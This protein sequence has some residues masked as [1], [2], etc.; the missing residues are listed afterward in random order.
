[1]DVGFIGL[2]SMGRGMARNLIKAGH[3]VSVFNRSKEPADELAREGALKAGS[4]AAVGGE[5]VVTMLSDD[6]ALEAVVL[7]S[8]GLIT[9]MRRGAVHLSMSTVSVA[10]S[11]RLEDAHRNANQA[12]V[13]APVFGRP[14]AAAAGKLFIVAAGGHQAIER[15]RPVMNAM[16]QRIFEVGGKASQANIVKLAGNFLITC[17]IEGFAETM[18]LNSKAGVAPEK[19]YEVMTESLFN[20]PVYRNYGRII[21]DGAY[22]PP[23][24]KLPLGLK[25][26]RL[27]LQAADSL[28]VPLPFA[29]V[30]RDRFLASL[31]KGD[32]DLDW[33]AIAKRAR[34][35]AGLEPTIA[36]S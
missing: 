33:A 34:E 6:A 18:A 14:D 23:G 29:A 32:G 1:M 30:V 16:G 24:F 35:D 17:V 28:N 31:A 12:Y 25:D 15:A 5:V 3:R 11:D 20:A 26:N 36:A 13:A 8:G 21:L 2:G 4:P 27:L 7:G 22:S 10:L 19:F 9:G